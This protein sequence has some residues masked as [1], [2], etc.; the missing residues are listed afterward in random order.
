MDNPLKQNLWSRTPRGREV[1]EKGLSASGGDWEWPP[2]PL[3]STTW[4]ISTRSLIQFFLLGEN[5]SG[6]TTVGA[7]RAEGPKGIMKE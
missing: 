6:I 2:L 4:V 1:F 3:L 7:K 5:S